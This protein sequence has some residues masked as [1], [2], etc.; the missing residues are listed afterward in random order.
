MWNLDKEHW[1]TANHILR[2][3]RGTIM[4]GLRYASNNEVKL[5]GFTD[6]DWARS[7]EDRKSTYGLCFSLGFAMISWDSR[8]QKYV[9]LSTMEA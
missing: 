7:V 4:Y 5:H 9:A 8:K 1:V 3:L 6:L 2:Y